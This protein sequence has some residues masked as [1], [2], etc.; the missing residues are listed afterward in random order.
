MIIQKTG[1]IFT[2][3][4]TVI[5]HG[6][7][8]EGIMGHGIAATVRALFPD[9]YSAYRYECRQG[10]LIGGDMFP[11]QSSKGP[12]ILN[13][14]SQEAPGRNAKYSFLEDG[15][16]KS[17]LWC[18]ENGIDGFALPK[19]GAGIGGLEWEQVEEILTRLAERHPKVDLEIWTFEKAKK[20]WQTLF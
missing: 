13:I 11:Y 19:I 3:D 4:M 9:V 16:E 14:A 8:I 5:G 17:F 12:W 2:S 6:V 20:A 15:V 1:D 10:R 7:N 18:E